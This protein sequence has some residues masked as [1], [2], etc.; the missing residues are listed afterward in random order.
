VI[1]SLLDCTKILLSSRLH[2]WRRLKSVVTVEILPQAILLEYT[3][4][5]GPRTGRLKS[6]RSVGYAPRSFHTFAFCCRFLSEW[7]EN[8][9]T[10]L[11]P[12]VG[13]R[14]L[15]FQ[16]SYEPMESYVNI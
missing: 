5:N 10:N 3:R 6:D 13:R 14:L 12:L 4:P 11:Q 2:W 8:I 7:N 1:R 9:C 15:H 16:L